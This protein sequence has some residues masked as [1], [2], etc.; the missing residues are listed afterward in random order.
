ML[1]ACLGYFVDEQRPHTP[2]EVVAR[3]PCCLATSGA[4]TLLTCGFDPHSQ[5][6]GCCV[7]WM[8]KKQP[9]LFNPLTRRTLSRAWVLNDRFSFPLWYKQRVAEFL[10]LLF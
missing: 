8:A 2:L 6:V 5:R 1:L 7:V 9:L 4:L 3:L 10:T